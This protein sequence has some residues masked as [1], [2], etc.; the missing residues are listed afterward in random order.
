MYRL[1]ALPLCVDVDTGKDQVALGVSRQITPAKVDFL[2]FS[3]N[4]F[5]T[6]VMDL[7]TNNK[8]LLIEKD[9]T[10]TGNAVKPP[11][12]A[13]TYQLLILRIPDKISAKKTESQR[14]LSSNRYLNS[15]VL[16]SRDLAPTLRDDICGR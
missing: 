15:P 3:N 10:K 14:D 12:P 8:W 2:S 13:F 9:A 16:Q 5:M 11:S 4:I 1:D 6:N 7:F